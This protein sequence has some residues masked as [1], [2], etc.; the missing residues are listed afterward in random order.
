MINKENTI[1]MTLSRYFAN[2]KNDLNSEPGP[3]IRN[4]KCFIRSF[5]KT[6]LKPCIPLNIC[7][8]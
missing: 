4:M 5:S 8:F 7:S 1:R 2:P 3:K 6:S